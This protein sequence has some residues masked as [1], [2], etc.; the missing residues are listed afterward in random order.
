MKDNKRELIKLSVSDI[1]NWV[2]CYKTTNKLPSQFV[3]CSKCNLGIV[4]THSNLHGRVLKFGGVDKLLKSFVCKEC[5]T[6][7]KP[8]ETIKIKKEKK[9][10]QLKSIVVDEPVI[11]YCNPIYK[12][13]PKVTVTY[14]DL[15][16]NPEMCAKMTDGQC[17][18]VQFHL[19][20]GHQCEDKK[21]NVCSIYEHCGV[22]SKN[23]SK[24]T[25]KKF[26][27]N[28]L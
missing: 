27:G 1:S 2:S 23:V 12:Q 21:G 20:N 8:I 10:K 24:S 3:P 18:N 14:K 4:M 16:R 5:K 11:D 9:L 19:N 17:W 26:N 28:K 25:Q 13:S 7:S 22:Q 15:I 6:L